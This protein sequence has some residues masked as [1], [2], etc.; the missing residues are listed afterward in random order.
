VQHLVAWCCAPLTL[1]VL[2]AA[3]RWKFRWSVA[4]HR[5]IRERFRSEI[6]AAPGP[7]MIC[8]NHLTM[9][10]S[11]IILWALAP[12]WW[13][14]LHFKKV[15]WNVPER[16]N[17]AH[18]LL[19]RIG[20]YLAK[21]IPIERGGDR[22]VVSRVLKRLHGLL[23][24]GHVVLLFPEGGRS[25]TGRVDGANP[26]LGPGRLVKDLPGARVLCVY[27]RGDHQE[28]VSDFPVRC[29]RFTCMTSWIE[30]R[31]EH[32]GLRGSVEL[33]AKIIE[34]LRGMEERYFDDRQRRR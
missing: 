26:A 34:R 6:S 17:F 28:G 10:D 16:K 31:T 23:D 15:P 32:A 21:C 19:S 2:A 8:A 11:I 1:G 13:Y 29:E 24:R 25:R 20:V 3:V 5:Q 14:L 33:S 18:D 22:S 9:I 7:V 30:P 12:M 27:L 4:D